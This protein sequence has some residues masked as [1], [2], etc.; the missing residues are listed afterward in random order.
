MELRAWVHRSVFAAACL[1][2]AVNMVAAQITT[3]SIA[4][5]I[6]DGQGGVL[7]GATVTLI[8]ETQSTKSAPVITDATGDFVFVN[9]KPDTYT[10]EITMPSFRTL[11]RAGVPVSPG[12][13][14]SLGA[15]V[16]ELGGATEV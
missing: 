12:Q 15:L 6:K 7:P 4:G 10:V 3:G 14:V 16:L 2:V 1:L 11:R 9:L 8:S 5:T 13:R